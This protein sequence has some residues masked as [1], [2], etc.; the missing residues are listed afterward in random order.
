MK[1]KLLTIKNLPLLISQLSNRKI[2]SAKNRVTQERFFCFDL[3][4]DEDLFDIEVILNGSMIF[5]FPY[6]INYRFMF[7]GT[8]DVDKRTGYVFEPT[9]LSK[10]DTNVRKQLENFSLV[11]PDYIFFSLLNVCFSKGLFQY[12]DIFNVGKLKYLDKQLFDFHG[13]TLENTPDRLNTSRLFIQRVLIPDHLKL[14]RGLNNNSYETK[15]SEVIAFCNENG[16]SINS[17][18]NGYFFGKESNIWYEAFLKGATKR[19]GFIRL[20]NKRDT[21][22]SFTIE[23][24]VDRQFRGAAY[25]DEMINCVRWLLRENAHALKLLAV[26]PQGLKFSQNTL[27]MNKFNFSHRANNSAVYEYDILKEVDQDI[28]RKYRNNNL[29]IR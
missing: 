23:V 15:K 27:K 22:S 20:H 14:F 3:L 21:P 24:I 29:K 13:I 7:T 18:S 19:I 12:K 9:C 8:I 10:H 1:Y 28:L 26:I 5:G 17:V 2:G 6:G 25:A 16:F 11:L 4:V